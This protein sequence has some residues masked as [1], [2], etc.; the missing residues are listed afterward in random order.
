MF[1]IYI[2]RIIV[3]DCESL[4]VTEL[5][6]RLLF[7]PHY[8]E[9]HLQGREY[10]SMQDYL[11][12]DNVKYSWAKYLIDFYLEYIRN[13]EDKKDDTIT[14]PELETLKKQLL[15]LI[16]QRDELDKQ[17]EDIKV[18]IELMSEGKNNARK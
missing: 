4:G 8:R 10:M 11:E 13:K 7:N 1:A 14:S 3:R 6:V 2:R 16:S 9:R 5:Y 15:S 18:Q 17:I 12:K